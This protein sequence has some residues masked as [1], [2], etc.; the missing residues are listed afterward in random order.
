VNNALRHGR[1]R[2]VVVEMEEQTETGM[3]R[4][5]VQDDGVGFHGPTGREA[6]T[7]HFGIVSMRERAERL[8][9]RLEI[10]SAP[11]HGTTVT[12]EIDRRD[13]DEQIDSAASAATG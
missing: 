6:A 3:L 5:T 13:Y 11:G 9:G 12:V 4:A 8:G 2:H 1:P 7:G 10:A